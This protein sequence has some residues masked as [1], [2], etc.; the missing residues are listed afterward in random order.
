MDDVSFNESEYARR[1]AHPSSKSGL[2]SLV[3]RTGIVKTEAAA[4]K[5]LLAVAVLAIVATVLILISAGNNTAPPQPLP[6]ELI[7]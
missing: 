4:Q 3:I 7:R 5:V 6:E 1:E 2:S